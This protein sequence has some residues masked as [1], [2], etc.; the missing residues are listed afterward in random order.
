MERE[1]VGRIH[2]NICYYII[3]N[4]LN[5]IFAVKRHLKSQMSHIVGASKTNTGAYRRK[6]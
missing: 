3:A 6:G 4:K 1:N 2:N 5:E